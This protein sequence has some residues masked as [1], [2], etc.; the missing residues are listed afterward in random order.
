M[1][2]Q[3]G[4]LLL[5]RVTP[6]STLLDKLIGWG[7]KRIHQ[8]P[9]DAA[10]C[11][12]A[13]VGP[14]AGSMYEAVAPKPHNIPIDWSKLTK[15]NTIDVFR[16]TGATPEQVAKV[17]AYCQ[18]VVDAGTHYDWLAIATMGLV[19]LGRDCVCSQLAWQGWC[20]GDVILCDWQDLES[21]D[22]VAASKKTTLVG[23]VIRELPPH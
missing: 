16:V 11:H 9:T 7:Q 20:D 8:A 12:V 21:P 2:V 5:F 23:T 13:I 3:P 19:Q 15:R 17:M 4:D 10:Y 22:D 18:K 1:D 14:D 6:G